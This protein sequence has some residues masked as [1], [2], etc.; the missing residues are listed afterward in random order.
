MPGVD[1][2]MRQWSFFQ[3]LEHNAI[4]NRSITAVVT[5]LASNEEPTGA[6]AID[7]KRDVL[8]AADAG[9]AQV[10]RLG[11]LRGTRRKVHPVFGPFDAHRWH[12]MLGFHLAIH[13]GQAR[14]IVAGAGGGG[15]RGRGAS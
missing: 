2:D 1:P 9:P 11:R 5:S 6:G 4:V 12:G 3:L 7:P 8:P 15:A 10:A 13:L 14:R